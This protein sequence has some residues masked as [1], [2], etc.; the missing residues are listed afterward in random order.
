MEP[1]ESKPFLSARMYDFLKQL[2]QL[3][4]PALGTLYFTI[5]AIWG[6]PAAEEVVGTLAA[7]ATFGG[8]VLGI[9]KSRYDNSDER[10]VGE[11][12]LTLTDDD[13]LKRVFNVTDE[14]VMT[15]NTGKKELTFKVVD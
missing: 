8:V 6:L 7:V 14:Q 15:A 13:E 4:L 12:F 1:V 10:F 11:T 3:I 2:V 9:S 5:A